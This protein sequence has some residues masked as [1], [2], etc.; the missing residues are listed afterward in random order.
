MMRTLSMWLRNVE[1]GFYKRSINGALALHRRNEVRLDGLALQSLCNRLEICWHARDVHPW[2]RS[3]SPERQKATFHQQ[4]ME[5]TEAAVLRIFE[6]RPEVQ[7]IELRVLEPHS[8]AVLASGTVHRSAIN[9]TEHHSPSIRMRLGALGIR[10]H[11]ALLDATT[12]E[13]E[14]AQHACKETDQRRIA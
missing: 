8:N 13:L 2:D 14:P 4:A 1:L 10:C 12:P 6:S 3:S 7:V 11:Y 5:D 9:V